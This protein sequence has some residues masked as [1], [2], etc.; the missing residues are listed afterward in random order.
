[1]TT[2]DFYC[3]LNQQVT[4]LC[5]SL[6]PCMRVGAIMFLME[7]MHINVGDTLDYFKQYYP[8][9]WSIVHWL[10]NV[11]NKLVMISDDYVDSLLGCQ[12]MA[13]LLH[14]LDDHLVDGDVPLSHMTLLIRSQAWLRMNECINRFCAGVQDGIETARGLIDDYYV[15]IMEVEVPSSLD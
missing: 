12:A 7:Y 6:S 11:H 5:R 3:R 4:G 8:P 13:M 10:A 1:M 15:G 9:S 2:A 14:S